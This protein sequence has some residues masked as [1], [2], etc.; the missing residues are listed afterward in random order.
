MSREV[1]EQRRGFDPDVPPADRA[2]NIALMLMPAPFYDLLCT[3][4]HPELTTRTAMQVGGEDRPDW[5]M[6]RHWRQFADETGNGFKLVRQSVFTLSQTL[7]AEA[8]D[9]AEGFRQKYGSCE[10]LDQIL[11]LVRSR[12]RKVSGV[13]A[14]AG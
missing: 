3:A 11:E 8:R 1:A 6:Q 12:C 14:S 5:I 7:P 4:V 2:K 9:E 13:L 10:I